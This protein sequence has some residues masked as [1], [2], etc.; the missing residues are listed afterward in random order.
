MLATALAVACLLLAMA[1]AKAAGDADWAICDRAIS[2]AEDRHGLPDGLLAAIA[3][4]ESGRWSKEAA[5]RTAWPWTIYAEGRGR[6]LASRA[7]TLAEIRSLRAKGVRNIDIGCMQVNFHFHGKEFDSL[8]QMID[9]AHNAD[10]AARFLKSLQTETETWTRAVGYYHSRTPSHSK[11]Y[12]DRVLGFW[13]DRNGHGEDD[14]R[15]PAPPSRTAQ[16]PRSNPQ[17]VAA[18]PAITALTAVTALTDGRR[19]ADDETRLAAADIEAEEAGAGT[20]APRTPPSRAHMPQIARGATAGPAL[21]TSRGI[22][23]S[24]TGQTL[25]MMRGSG[26]I[27]LR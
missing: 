12:R 16:P 24:P 22:Y 10:Y 17:S 20:I 3:L 19:P 15:R 26:S 11:P 14:A 13:L 27:A 25:R 9:P 1:P 7:E 21:P 6:Y 8:E 2:A 4:A 23:R 18:L 5:A